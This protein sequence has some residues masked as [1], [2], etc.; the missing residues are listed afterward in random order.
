[1]TATPDHEPVARAPM[2]LRLLVLFVVLWLGVKI[3]HNVTDSL[4]SMTGVT[5]VVKSQG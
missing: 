5:H 4:I 1:M 2:W 3:V